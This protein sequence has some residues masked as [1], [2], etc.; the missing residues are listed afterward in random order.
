M[1]PLFTVAI[2]VLAAATT[3][4]HADVFDNFTYTYTLNGITTTDT[5]S[6]IDGQ[7]ATNNRQNSVIYDPVV[8]NGDPNTF[9]EI[10]FNPPSV[11]FDHGGNI[12]SYS[13]LTFHLDSGTDA[14]QYAFGLSYSANAFKTFSLLGITFNPGTYVFPYGYLGA[15]AQNFTSSSLTIT[16]SDTPFIPTPTPDP[17]PVAATPEPASL[18]LLGTGLLGLSILARRRFP[19]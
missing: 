7:P 11:Q 4:A 10:T 5:F 18:S 14:S 6:L 9:T 19:A 3:S 8:I 17:T 1:R 15:G 12:T 16:Q 13:G 2:L